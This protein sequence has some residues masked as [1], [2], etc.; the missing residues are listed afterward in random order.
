MSAPIRVVHSIVSCRIL[1][2]L[3]RAAS[4]RD[5]STAIRSISLTFAPAPEPETNLVDTIRLEVRGGEEDSCL[6]DFVVGSNG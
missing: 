4:P 3:R 5:G 1:L 2:N 6:G